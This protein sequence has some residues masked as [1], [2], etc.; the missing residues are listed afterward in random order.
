MSPQILV[1][2]DF[3]NEFIGT[4][5]ASTVGCGAVLFIR[6]LRPYLYGKRFVVKTDHRPLAFLYN[7]KDPT[8]RLARI[9]LDLAEYDFDILYIK[10]VTNVVAD[11]L[12]R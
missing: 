7:L 2:P 10:G 5:D 6:H 4:T 11:A 12:S 3:K 8:S 1:Y 9:R